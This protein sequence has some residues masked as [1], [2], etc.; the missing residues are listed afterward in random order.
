MKQ[1]DT[2]AHWRDSAIVP[3][4]FVVDARAAFAIVLLLFKPSWTTLGIAVVVITF[5]AFLN[6][7]K[8]PVVVAYRILKSWCAGP[9][10]ILVF[11]R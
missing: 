2:Q 4:F 5:L 8:L 1:D 7:K 11:K 6:V 9:K 3:Q 10:K